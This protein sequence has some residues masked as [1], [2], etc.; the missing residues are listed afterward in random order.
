MTF[1]TKCMHFLTDINIIVLYCLMQKKLRYLQVFAKALPKSGFGCMR[2]SETMRSTI[3]NLDEKY[4][5]GVPIFRLNIKS[6]G[7]IYFNLL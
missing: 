7:F 4:N 5:I 1:A 2:A 6:C 3:T